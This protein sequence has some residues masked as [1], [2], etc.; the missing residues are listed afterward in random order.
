M[1]HFLLTIYTNGQTIFE[2]LFYTSTI[3]MEVLSVSVNKSTDETS[4]AIKKNSIR[5]SGHHTI[6]GA[7]T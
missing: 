4:D 7:S 6:I 1:K 3:T 5:L 2:I